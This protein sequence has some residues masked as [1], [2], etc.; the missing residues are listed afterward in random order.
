MYDPKQM[1][2]MQQMFQQP[3]GAGQMPPGTGGIA[4]GG[5][6]I[7]PISG[8]P[9]MASGGVQNIPNWDPSQDP[10]FQNMPFDPSQ[11]PGFQNLGGDQFGPAQQ[12]PSS[13]GG[14]SPAARG[15]QPVGRPMPADPNHPGIARPMPMPMPQGRPRPFGNGAYP[16]DLGGGV[17]GAPHRRGSDG[18]PRVPGHLRPNMDNMPPMGGAGGN[19]D[20]MPVDAQDPQ[21]TK[22]RMRDALIQSILAAN[23]GG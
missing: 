14:W 1:A 13:P 18:M 10:G 21:G 6:P 2:L 5:V 8:G 23:G 15:G 7:G 11:D 9:D 19:I 22:K 20:N 3:M 4:A 17:Q 16:K 12:M